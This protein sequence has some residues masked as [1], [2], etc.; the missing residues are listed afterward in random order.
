M[1]TRT[2]PGQTIVAIATP[3]GAGAVGIIRLS[4]PEALA[5]AAR[6]FRPSHS[7][8]S[9]LLPPWRLRLGHVLDASGSV[10][11]EVLAVA[12]PGPRSFS[13]EDTVEFHC[14]GSP[15]V[16]ASILD[17]VV[18]A[19][20]RPAGP[21][22]FTCRAFL[23]GRLDLAQAEAVAELVAAPGREAARLAL[24]SLSGLLSARV[25]ALRDRLTELRAAICLAVDFPEDE[26]DG[27]DRDGFLNRLDEVMSEIR[28]LLAAGERG[29]VAREGARV[30][31]AG[32]VNAGKSSLMNALLGRERAIVTPQPGTTRDF[33]EEPLDLGGLTV[34]LV[35][36]AGLRETE[37]AV[38]RAGLRFSRELMAA[39]DLVV[40]VVDGSRAGAAGG[41][42]LS[43]FAPERTLVALNKADLPPAAPDPMVRLSALG[44]ETLRLSARTGRGVDILAKRLRERLA[45]TMPQGEAAPAPNLRQRQA[46]SLALAELTALSADARSGRPEDILGVG[47]ETACAQLSTITGEIVSEDV[48]AD[49]FSRFCIGK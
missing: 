21:G 25:A 29:R 14:H 1:N 39:A 10:L 16:L 37:D 30:V 23:N 12:M 43:G 26:T 5:I 22:E 45:G 47:L 49:I 8:S 6:L 36:T 44:L 38:E 48:L 15:A 41:H 4:G 42:D 7:T 18:A 33:I 46:L 9:T 31:L 19:G 11:D 32:A 40:L 28:A 34:R 17:A 3:P 24:S 35:D 27:F 13:G 2:P 20:A